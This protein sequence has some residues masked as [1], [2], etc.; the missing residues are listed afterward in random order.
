M[1]Q[2]AENMVC[3]ELLSEGGLL[4]SE[5]EREAVTSFLNFKGLL[6]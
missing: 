5:E 2:N 4:S 3:V 6:K 1:M